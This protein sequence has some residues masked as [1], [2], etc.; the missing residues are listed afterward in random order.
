M[1][2]PPRKVPPLLWAGVL[3]TVATLT[4]LFVQIKLRAR[5]SKPLPVYGQ[6]ADFNLTNQLGRGVSL[7]D[8]RDHVWLADIIFTRCPGP[9]LSMSRKMQQISQ[10]LPP[11]SEIKLVSLTTDPEYDNP[12]IL[13]TYSQQV[14]ADP[15]RWIFLTGSKIEIA[16]L[17]ID[18]LK[19]TAIDKKPEERQSSDDLFIHSTIFVL[20]DKR[21][22]LRGVFETTGEEI[23]WQKIQTEILAALHRLEREP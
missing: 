2:P 5:F 4:L 1:N 14:G 6:V 16:K 17:A 3:L 23:D 9:C 7:A 21:G 8:L 11:N 15:G 22:Q 19:L 10:A 13:K 18:S 12:A 20:V